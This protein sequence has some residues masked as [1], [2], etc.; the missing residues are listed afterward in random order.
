MDLPALRGWIAETL[1]FF[2]LLS[3]GCLSPKSRRL[4]GMDGKTETAHTRTATRM[5][6]AVTE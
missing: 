1:L 6:D 4:N 5:L 2:S 3:V